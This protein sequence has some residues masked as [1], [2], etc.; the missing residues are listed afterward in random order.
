[1]KHNKTYLP[2]GKVIHRVTGRGMDLHGVHVPLQR[3]KEIEHAV[4]GGGIS[5]AAIKRLE[6]LR[7]RIPLVTKRQNIKF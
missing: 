1:M 2:C 7:P 3:I 5:E 4:K 6:E